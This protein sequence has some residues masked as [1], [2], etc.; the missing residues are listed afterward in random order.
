MPPLT[1]KLAA[2]LHQVLNAE[3]TA[4]LSIPFLATLMARGVWYWQDFTWQVGLVLSIAA[5][6]GS[7]YLY[8]KQALTWTEE[9]EKDIVVVSEE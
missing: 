8:G 2:R 6:G 1:D 4:I 5:T 9:D 3:I 7:F